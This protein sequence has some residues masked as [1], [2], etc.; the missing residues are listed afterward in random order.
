VSTPSS[1]PEPPG[2]ARPASRRAM[3]TGTAVGVAGLT[4]GMMLRNPAPALAA[5]T[6]TTLDWINVAASPYNADPTGAS[7]SQAAIQEA[8]GAVP[9]GG[10]VCYMPAGTYCISEPLTLPAGV[11]LRGAYGEVYPNY[12]ATTNEYGTTIRPWSTWT[13]AS[14]PGI[15][16]VNGIAAAVTD[17]NILGVQPNGTQ[18]GGGIHG[19][20]NPSG[21]NV[22]NVLLRNLVI[23][24]VPGSGVNQNGSATWR[25]DNVYVASA[26]YSGFAMSGTDTNVTNCSALGC[27]QYGWFIN[28]PMN[29]K[30]TG[31]RAETCNLDGFTLQGDNTA[32]GGCQ[33]T[34]ISTD[35][36]NGNGMSIAATGNWP[37]LIS[38]YQSRRDGQG[39]GQSAI[40]YAGSTNPVIIDGLTVFPGSVGTSSGPQYGIGYS[41]NSTYGSFLSVTNALIHVDAGG[42]PLDIAKPNVMRAVSTRIGAWDIQPI[43]TT[44]VADNA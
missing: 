21:V 41:V 8:I 31:C 5:D 16:N 36:N 25:Y 44:L 6:G 39:G 20:S 35:A 3:L 30:F 17:L 12:T 14:S 37:I 29:C 18:I 26:G 19:I 4:G 34:G 1:N 23:N 2:P 10:G 33:L 13:P 28:N 11:L 38:G 32:T 27:G 7:D 24:L 15:I 22:N 40:Y 43:T 9:A 42:T